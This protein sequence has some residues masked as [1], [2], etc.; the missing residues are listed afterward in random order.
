MEERWK[1]E[2][3]KYGARGLEE[4]V[5]GRWKGDRGGEKQH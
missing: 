2:V 1:G 3:E 5:D 4:K